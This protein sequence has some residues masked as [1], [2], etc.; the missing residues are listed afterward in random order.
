M[1]ATVSSSTITA[2]ASTVT[3]EWT[4]AYQ[5]PSRPPPC[6]P[7]GPGKCKITQLQVDDDV[8]LMQR[9]KQQKR[10]PLHVTQKVEA[11]D[12]CLSGSSVVD[13][14]D[15]DCPAITTSGGSGMPPVSSPGLAIPSLRLSRCR[16]SP[17]LSLILGLRP[18]WSQTQLAL[19]T[20]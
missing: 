11:V 9:S 5:G 17:S 6:S 19:P 3:S 15:V 2:S 1:L 8:P 13:P 16:R 7:Q 20:H 18:C 4:R 10:R 12:E 14:L